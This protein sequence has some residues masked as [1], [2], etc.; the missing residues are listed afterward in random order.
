MATVGLHIPFLSPQISDVDLGSLGP[1][2]KLMVAKPYQME[3]LGARFVTRENRNF[4]SN[5]G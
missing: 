1:V 4:S 2:V 3:T 5:H